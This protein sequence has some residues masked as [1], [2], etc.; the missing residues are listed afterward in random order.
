MKVDKIGKGTS[1]SSKLR[2][3]RDYKFTVSE[4]TC[5]HTPENETCICHGDRGMI[6]NCT[7]LPCSDVCRTD[8]ELK[9]Q[10][11][12]NPRISLLH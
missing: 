4:K 1:V 3:G 2:L 9:Q 7:C 8:W 12:S 11:R 5:T 6:N 10:R